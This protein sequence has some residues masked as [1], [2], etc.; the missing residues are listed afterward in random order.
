MA[1]AG[2]RAEARWLVSDALSK[3]VWGYDEGDFEL[4]GD[5]FTE[6]AVAWGRVAQSEQGWGPL[7]GRAEIVRV[8]SGIRAS[9]TDQRRHAISN[10]LF[11]DLTDTTARVR[12]TLVLVA[13]QDGVPRLVSGGW[14]R[15]L[16]VRDGDTW[17]IREQEA[18]LD[19]PF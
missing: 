15:C 5:A 14:Y 3:Y 4:L 6:D 8:L 18:L 2:V 12:C 1:D 10:I 19:S 17:R 11:D 13:T 9:Q 16:V 7:T